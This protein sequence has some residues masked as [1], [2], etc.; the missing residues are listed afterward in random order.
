M[1]THWLGKTL[2]SFCAT[3]AEI[4]PVY[5]AVRKEKQRF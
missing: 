4:P 1:L 5:V 3:L 2:A